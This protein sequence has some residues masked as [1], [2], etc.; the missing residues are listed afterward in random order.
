VVAAVV[1]VVANTVPV[2]PTPV[3][4]AMLALP[5]V[6]TDKAKAAAMAPVVVVAV[7]DNLV[8]LVD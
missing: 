6:A 5:M 8:V 2:N 1:V 7:V 3:L 4:Q